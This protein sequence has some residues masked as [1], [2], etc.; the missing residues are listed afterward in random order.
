MPFLHA[1][2][3]V[4]R[5]PVGKPL[6][7]HLS[8]PADAS[9]GAPA[10]RSD[11]GRVVTA[12]PEYRRDNALLPVDLLPAIVASA[13]PALIDPARSPILASAAPDFRSF[14]Q[15]RPSARAPPVV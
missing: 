12:A 13:P 4:L 5:T 6:H 1:H 3:G 15:H 2:A 14:S 10:F 11:E 9:G 7:L 8:L